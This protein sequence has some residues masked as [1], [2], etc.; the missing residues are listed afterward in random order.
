MYLGDPLRFTA[1]GIGSIDVEFDSVTVGIFEIQRFGHFVND[2]S[3]LDAGGFKMVFGLAQLIE[4]LA[5]LEGDVV[6]TDAVFAARFVLAADFHDGKIM[7]I[8]E[9]KERHLHAGLVEPRTDG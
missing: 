7:M 3:R 9:R 2:W 5:D 4:G 1:P 6:K 8:A